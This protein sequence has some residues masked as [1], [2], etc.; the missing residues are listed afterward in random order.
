MKENK[1]LHNLP[2]IYLSSKKI[3][4]IS[5][6]KILNISSKKIL[7]RCNNNDINLIDL[8]D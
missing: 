1:I 2:N 4:N 5:S 3:L 8:S 7:N 6:K